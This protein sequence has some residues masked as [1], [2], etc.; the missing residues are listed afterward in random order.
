MI[1]LIFL[2]LVTFELLMV[3]FNNDGKHWLSLLSDLVSA[4]VVL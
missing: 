3:L 1:F 4:S 2:M